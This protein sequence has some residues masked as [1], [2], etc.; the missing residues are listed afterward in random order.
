MEKFTLKK[1][2]EEAE[3]TDLSSR[4]S[5]SL[6]LE[7]SPEEEES[8]ES[9]EESTLKSEMFSNTSWRM[10]SETPSPTPNTP[11]EEPSLLKTLFT[12]W[13]D[14]EELYMVSENDHN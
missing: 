2:S 13:R 14:K 10:S 8:R 7:D 9:P 11:R 5:P 1:E 6:L 12:L 3:E 4:V